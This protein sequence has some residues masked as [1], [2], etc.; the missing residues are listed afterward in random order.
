MIFIQ[1][2]G[3]ICQG[4]DIVVGQFLA[5]VQYLSLILPVTFDQYKFC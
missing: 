2:Q 5:F 4:M 3:K 1:V